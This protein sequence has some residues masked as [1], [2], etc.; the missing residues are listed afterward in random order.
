[1]CAAL[2]ALQTSKRYSNSSHVRRKCDSLAF[3]MACEI[4]SRKFLWHW[5]LV[6]PVFP[7]SSYVEVARSK[8]R[9]SRGQRNGSCSSYTSPLHLG[10]DFPLIVMRGPLATDKLQL[11][12][13]TKT[14]RVSL[15]FSSTFMSVPVTVSKIH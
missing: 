7:I 2:V 14:L 12:F 13:L 9:G 6:Y 15:L 1:M 3:A 11:M 10:N 4:R 5:R 8:L